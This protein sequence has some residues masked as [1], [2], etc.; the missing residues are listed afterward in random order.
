MNPLIPPSGAIA[1]T[2]PGRLLAAVSSAADLTAVAQ[3]LA[4]ELGSWLQ[5]GA[6]A[7]LLRQRG[8]EVKLATSREIPPAL[9]RSLS[10]LAGLDDEAAEPRFFAAVE[11]DPLWRDEAPGFAAAGAAACWSFP[12]HSLDRGD[13]GHARPQAEVIGWVAFLHSGSRSPSPE[14]RGL[15]TLAATLAGLALEAF[16]LRLQAR[17]ERF[18]DPLTRLPNRRLFNDEVERGL[19]H[20]SP[21]HN[22]MAVV[23]LD[24]DRFGAVNETLGLVVGDRVLQRVAARLAGEFRPPDLLCRYGD[25]EFAVLLAEVSGESG[26]EKLGDR[27]MALLRRPYDFAG[28]EV[29]VSASV[30]I[31]VYPWHGEDGR[32]LIRSAEKALAV[33]KGRGRNRYQLYSPV[34]GAGDHENLRLLSGLPQVVERQELELLYQVQVS[35]ADGRILGVEALVYWQHPHLGVVGPGRF[36]PLAEEAGLMGPITDWVLQQAVSQVATW[37]RSGLEDLRVAVNMSAPQFRDADLVDRVTALLDHHRLPPGL[38]QL[39]ITERTAMT[40]P[41]LVAER[42]RALHRLGVGVAVD[43]FGTGYSSLAMLKKLALRELKID[44]SFIRN[45]PENRESSAIVEAILALAQALGLEVVAEGVEN[46]RQAGFLSRRGCQV[47]QGYL[48][49]KPQSAEAV[50]A[51]LR[52][53]LDPKSHRVH[54]PAFRGHDPLAGTVHLGPRRPHRR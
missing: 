17:Y 23:L 18:Y 29:F 52:A 42:C 16:R 46:R 3:A 47:L 2:G 9:Q 25:D 21:R 20:A 19:E 30:G 48:F 54:H 27:L 15:L 11:A 22:R 32:F 13:K 53:N 44:R 35:S 43:D 8:S 33:A 41:S 4:E 51:M 7:V 40:D 50:S 1:D 12:V 36:V 34:L 10:R 31:G 5:G 14:Q 39:E 38:L 45:L 26:W 24:L 49:G 28:E 6:W 37:F